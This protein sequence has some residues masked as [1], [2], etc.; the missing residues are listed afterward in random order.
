[1]TAK[2]AVTA[3]IMGTKRSA[4]ILAAMSFSEKRVVEEG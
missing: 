1:M 3:W 4:G 2:T